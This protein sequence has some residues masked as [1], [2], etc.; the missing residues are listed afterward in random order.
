M[1]PG[2]IVRTS[3][4]V[5][6]IT[7]DSL[8]QVTRVD[9]NGA[10][11]GKYAY[12]P[13]GRLTTFNESGSTDASVST[14]NY[15]RLTD[16]TTG[17]LHQHWTFDSAGQVTSDDQVLGGTHRVRSHQWDAMQRYAKTT[18][19]D[20][21][22]TEY[23]YTA[24]GQLS[25][26]RQPGEL[27]NGSDVL[28]V[29]NWARLD[30]GTGMWTDQI[31]ANGRALMEITGEDVEI[32]H[33]T[34]QD[35]IAAI[36]DLDGNV[37][38]QEEFAPFGARTAGTADGRFE[39]HFHGLRSD[40]LIVV[41]GRAYDPQAGSWLARDSIHRAPASFLKD[42]RLVNA[43]AF[44]FSNPYAYRDAN[45]MWP[46]EGAWDAVKD[47]AAERWEDVKTSAENA[48]HD[49]R[50]ASDWAWDHKAQIGAVVALAVLVV[51]T[52]G[53]ALGAAGG[54]GEGLLT[55]LLGGGGAMLS[56]EAEGIARVFEYHGD[57]VPHF[58]IEVQH[59]QRALHTEAFGK[60]T[61]DIVSEVPN[62]SAA[63]RTYEIPLPNAE[64]ALEYQQSILG[65]SAGE[66]ELLSN[67]C[68]THCGDV[69]S[70]GGISLPTSYNHVTSS[71]DVLNWLRVNF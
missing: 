51:A 45:G 29:G 11:V 62:P 18:I 30:I 10:L 6:G 15:D 44:D 70:A 19:L 40:E 17:G 50:D 47:F 8:H 20:G 64:A 34:I 33:R 23:F 22:T 42:V 48:W 46:G 59:G 9:L 2:G 3:P 58:S 27:P 16:R 41:G 7:V 65:T 32:P 39:Q 60:V 52:D 24:S 68:L 43:Y 37:V 4:D 69:L 56:N 57:N 1:K 66:F 26:V 12:D 21:T 49:I 38:R 25:L 61:W 36:T 31:T 5:F 28:Y 71:T 67:S 35:T 55:G 54:V 63:L 53:L 14:Y 13:A